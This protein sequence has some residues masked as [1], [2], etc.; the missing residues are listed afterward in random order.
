MVHNYA[1]NPDRSDDNPL[2]M[3]VAMQATHNPYEAP[4]YYCKDYKRINES[5]PTD[6]QK[7]CSTRFKFSGM[8]TGLDLAVKNITES[9]Q[10][11][12][13][14]DNTLLIFTST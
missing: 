9:F 4:D 3:Y 10:K 6:K 7:Q 12:G 1:T 11:Y 14:W 8:L 13:L 5:C 2:F